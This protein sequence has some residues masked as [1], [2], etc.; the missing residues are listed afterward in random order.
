MQSP[1][2]LW[3]SFTSRPQN[4]GSRAA[5]RLEAQHRSALHERCRVPRS[6]AGMQLLHRVG[7]I[8]GARFAHRVHHRRLHGLFQWCSLGQAS[9]VHALRIGAAFHTIESIKRHRHRE[10]RGGRRMQRR[11]QQLVHVHR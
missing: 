5:D 4:S 6:E 9:Q 3:A 11:S 8:G 2:V 1:S 7:D 10:R